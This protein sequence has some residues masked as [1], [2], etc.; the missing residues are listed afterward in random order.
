MMDNQ[1]TAAF[2]CLLRAG[3]WERDIDDKSVF[4]LSRSQWEDLFRT[5]I[6]QTVT[7]V[8]YRG[9]CQLH[10][11]LFPEDRIMMRWTVSI[12]RIERNS[13]I[14][15]NGIA[16]LAELLQTLEIKP[17]LLKGHSVASFYEHPQLRECGDIDLFFT[18]K[19]E[20]R[21]TRE[22]LKERGLRIDKQ[23]DGSYSYQWM[24]IEVEHHPALFDISNPKLRGYLEELTSGDKFQEF[25]IAG[26][27]APAPIQMLL[28][29]NAHLL[30]HLMGHG[31]G[32][33]Q[34]CDIAR[35]YHA[36]NGK[37]DKNRL[38]DVY[39]RTGILRWS[40]QLHTF[41]TENLGLDTS[42]L[43]FIEKDGR[44]SPT[45]LKIVMDGGNFGKA[46]TTRGEDTQKLW[47]RKMHTFSSFLKHSCFSM[48]YAPSETFWAVTNLIKGNLS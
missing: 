8:V 12:D 45:L 38:V 18:S 33:R 29:L 20:E 30:K 6:A 21:R 11:D 1:T 7:G 39:K 48:K 31:I 19:D 36:L 23:P 14:M 44:T 35:A 40:K 24:N 37:Y 17:I 25:H 47:K 27:L 5:S 10:E 16:A 28:L 32:L 43:P 46:G 2:F 41:L 13:M 34:F 3:L 9:I 22:A 15:S 42:D 26:I 4:P